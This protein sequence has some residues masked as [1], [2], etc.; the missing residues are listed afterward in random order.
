[1]TAT[2]NVI[3]QEKMAVIIQEVVG[4]DYDGLSI[5]RP[6]PAWGARSTIIRWATKSPTTEWP[7]WLS[8]SENT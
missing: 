7:K 2:S 3:D 1:M 4:E 5:S 6:S 8:G